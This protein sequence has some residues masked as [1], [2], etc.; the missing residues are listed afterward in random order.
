MRG[1]RIGMITAG[2]GA[3]FLAVLGTATYIYEAWQYT[4]LAMAGVM[5]VVSDT[6]P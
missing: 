3:L 6:L 2:A 5:L 4:Y 1:Y